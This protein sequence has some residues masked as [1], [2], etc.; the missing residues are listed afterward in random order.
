MTT[1]SD[2]FSIWATRARKMTPDM[3]THVIADCR[4]AAEAMRDWSPVKEGYYSDQA[5]TYSDELRARRSKARG[6]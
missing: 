1:T 6:R 2:D 5:A 4:A 3:L